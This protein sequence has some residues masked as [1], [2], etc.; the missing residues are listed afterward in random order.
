MRPTPVEVGRFDAPVQ[1]LHSALHPLFV[2]ALKL[3]GPLFVLLLGLA[4]FPNQA[5]YQN[6]R[7]AD[8]RRESEKCDD[9]DRSFHGPDLDRV[10]D[11]SSRWRQLG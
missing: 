9:A 1:R 3:L 5:A 8:G 6:G 2:S 7:T 10:T 4:A 11:E